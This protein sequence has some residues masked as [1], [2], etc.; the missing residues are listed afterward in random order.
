MFLW[1]WDARPYPAWPHTNIWQD[2]YLW[3]KGHWVNSKFGACSLA[4]IILE[5]SYKS[6]IDLAII[7]VTSLDESVEG[8][9][10]NKAI[11][12]IDAINYLRILYFFDIVANDR[13]NIKFIK[14]GLHEY[15][16]IS[17]DIL[18]KLTANS[19]LS[20][21]QISPKN[22]ISKL[23]LTFIDRYSDYRPGF[24]RVNNERDSYKP[25]MVLKLPIILSN[26]EMVRLGNLIL[27]NAATEDKVIKFNISTSFIK[28]EPSDFIKLDY[29]NYQYQI[30]IISI[31]FS[32]YVT[33]I[34][35][36]IDDVQNYYL[37]ALTEIQEIKYLQAEEIK[38]VILDHFDLPFIANGQKSLAI[39]L[40]SSTPQHLKYPS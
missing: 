15:Q 35:G 40:H 31:S 37:P 38:C 26:L 8:F 7:D 13:A 6:G 22:I 18:V 27:K 11:T 2:G 17:S 33:E 3:E 23:E 1:T 5:L 9:V 10:Q 32:R 16:T 36:I 34:T 39:Y 30:R 14:R 24:C 19:Y 25:V 12:S 28:Y 20:Q 29:L 21:T 4:A